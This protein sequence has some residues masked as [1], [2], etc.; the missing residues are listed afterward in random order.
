MKTKTTRS[1]K[2]RPSSNRRRESRGL[3]KMEALAAAR[4]VTPQQVA[5]HFKTKLSPPAEAT[6]PQAGVGRLNK[7]YAAKLP[8][9]LPPA[10]LDNIEYWDLL[11]EADLLLAMIDRTDPLGRSVAIGLGS[12]RR[13]MQ[14]MEDGKPLPDPAEMTAAI[15]RVCH[16][17]QSDRRRILRGWDYWRQPARKDIFE[18]KTNTITPVVDIHP[19]NDEPLGCMVGHRY[20]YCDTLAPLVVQIRW[21]ATREQVLRGLAD[22]V[23]IVLDHWQALI[24]DPQ[25]GTFD[26]LKGAQQA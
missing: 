25:E 13:E 20:V 24:T 8:P 16:L 18:L 21:G 19:S 2:A 12:A 14:D 6:S 17:G 5:E 10:D 11:E 7:P 15:D 22:A 4:G 26:F 3:A 23:R 9:P 1:K